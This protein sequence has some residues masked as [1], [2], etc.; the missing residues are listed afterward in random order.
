[1]CIYDIHFSER[2]GMLEV[3][4]SGFIWIFIQHKVVSSTVNLVSDLLKMVQVVK[5]ILH[6]VC[7]CKHSKLMRNFLVFAEEA[8]VKGYSII[9]TCQFLTI[10]K[11]NQN[12]VPKTMNFPIIKVESPALLYV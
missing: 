1:M 6:H 3:H 10:K 4:D 5:I 11:L 2:S 12:I 8:H 7:A 9:E